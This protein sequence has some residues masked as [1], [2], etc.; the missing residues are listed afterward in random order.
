SG[1]LLAGKGVSIKL[2]GDLTNSGTIA[3]RQIVELTAENVNNLGGRINGAAVTVQARNDL[4]NI[5]GQISAISKL[6]L[7]AGR[8]LNVTTTTQGGVQITGTAG[9]ASQ[10]INRVAGLYVTGDKGLLIASA[11]RDLNLTAAQVASTGQDSATTLSAGRN[12]NLG[13]VQTATSEQVTWAA[14][15]FRKTAV[16]QDVGTQVQGSGSVSIRAGQDV[17]VTAGTVQAGG[18]LDVA[19]V[20]DVKLAAGL[21][22]VDTGSSTQSTRKGFLSKTTNT[23]YSRMSDKTAQGSSLGGQ[24]VTVT[25][26]RDIAVN[27]A[28]VIADKD[29]TMKAVNNVTI[30]A[31]TNTRD[32]ESDASEKR[33][34]VFGSGGI[35]FTIGG[36]QQSTDTTVTSSSAA[37]STV[38]AIAG[39]VTIR[40]GNTYRQ[41]GSDVVAPAGDV[42]I[43][44]KQVL[45]DEA[46]E[47]STTLTEQ[48]SR[49]SGLTI[50]VT[51]PVISAVQ[52][53]GAMAKAAGNTSDGR[54]QALA[55]A[56]A[57]LAVKD[58][59][60]A[61]KDGQGVDFGNKSNQI[62][63][64]GEDG[65]LTGRDATAAEK[66]GGMNVA[67]SLGGSKS[68]STRTT[69]SDTAR[70]SSI[71]AGGSVRIQATGAGD[72]SNVVIQGSSVKAG[73]I[74]DLQADN[75]V[76][77]LAASNTASQASQDKSS[78]G[79]IGISMGTSGFGVTVSASQGRGNADGNDLSHTNTQIQ[80]RQVNIKSG[81]DTDI[82]GAVVT[83]DRVKAD[84]GGNLNV[85]SLQDTSKYKE[86]SK[87]AGG[88][89]TVGAG[90]S[91]SIS[92]SKTNIDSNYASVLEQSGIRAGD[93]GFQVNV[94][95]K[96]DLKGG[97]ITSTQKAIDN[98]VNVFDSKGG[99]TTSDVE[100]SA[101]YSAKA[102]AVNLGSAMNLSGQLTPQGTGV[103]VGSD[104]G[105][106]SSTT[107]AAI[108]GIAG[109]KDART[110]DSGAGI[111]PIFDQDK[112]KKE[113]NAQVTITQEAGRTIPKAWADYAVTQKKDL[114]AQAE[115]AKRSGDVTA[116]TELSG[117]AGKWD[118]GGLYRLLGHTVLGGLS[119]GASG[120]AGALTSATLMTSIG[121][122][123]DSA[124]LPD[125]VK[126][127]LNTVAAAAL[128]AVVGGLGG[129]ASSI[130]VEANNRQL[131]P[132]EKQLISKLSRDK[133][134]SSCFSNSKCEANA[135]TYW[136]DLLEKAALGM[137]D[138]A[139]AAANKRY[140]AEVEKTGSTPGSE[141]SSGAAATYLDNFKT[142]QAM[143]GAN[144]GQLIVVNGQITISHGSPQTY[145]SATNAQM[146][147]PLDN[148]G[149]FNPQGSIVPNMDARDASRLEA[150]KVQHGSAQ[151]IYPVEEVLLGGAVA[152][153]LAALA[154]KALGELDALIVG[155]PKATG[156]S[157]VNRA[158]FAMYKDGLI[159]QMDK[160][161][162]TNAELSAL[163]N[164][165]YRP[166]AKIGSGSTADAVRYET[167]TGQSVG[168]V[169]HTQKAGD[170]SIALQ[171]WIDKN[172]TASPG[173]RAAAENVL[174]DLQNALKGK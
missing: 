122:A 61:I 1:T 96:T 56:S 127:G 77:L 48:K 25:A 4:D 129:A 76:Q 100:N 99:I 57:A 38:G 24:D 95:G 155:P 157:A 144:A 172:P 111:K 94:Q 47:T 103:G 171:K 128:G 86:S 34:G 18:K 153:R 121:G 92:Y 69:T 19:A 115:A 137:E 116:Y 17:N 68:Q 37:A 32:T 67:I 14:S 10:G 148:V 113:V 5:G 73:D 123:I 66:A 108:S 80:G 43:R 16:T 12:V 98:G 70:G 23:E 63:T 83:G 40:A 97:A 132:T 131:H 44:G 91:G 85:E 156:E 87:S 124:Y 28:S 125:A 7:A 21:Q 41:T 90:V 55:G 133:A 49:Q 33:S 42:D 78:S 158:T 46:R 142:A 53:V 139:A 65:T 8:D 164:D 52:T 84:V 9:Y 11:G 60:K 141:G 26:G 159:S 154:G 29:L 166:G 89:L 143:L 146:A 54:M 79:S 104:K 135:T 168:E 130:N 6:D 3:G 50:A 162:V 151:P 150:L 101:N 45:I 51:S 81:G 126:Q 114:Q 62:V 117:E 30:T 120:A 119:G 105:S 35:G 22:T 36:R 169:F 145:F 170:Y 58:A 149:F 163:L 147:D 109:N 165:L 112:V 82:K 160:P 27:G 64:K 39:N 152:G 106:A 2:S 15:T 102:V 72:D 59:A 140:L 75:K 107:K 74:V 174:R 13:T 167:V 173:D 134:I 118:E 110:G 88:S 93:G 138:D 20:R 136:T 71:A 31:A 161:A